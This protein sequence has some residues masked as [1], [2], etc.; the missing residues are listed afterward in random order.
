MNR[1]LL[2]TMAVLAAPAQAHFFLEAPQSAWAQNAVGDPQKRPPCGNEAGTAPTNAVTTVEAGSTLTI[3]FRET[4]FHPGHY[5]VALGLTGPGDLPEPAPVT[6]GATPCGSTTVQSP[7]VFP[8]LADGMLHHSTALTGTQSFAVTIPANVSC[9]RCTLQ[10]IQFM[11]DHALNVPGGC[12][13]SHCA[14]LTIVPRDAGTAPVRDAGLDTDGGLVDAGRPLG[15]DDAGAPPSDAGVHD[16]SG[17]DHDRDPAPAMGCGCVAGAG[18]L[19]LWLLA[20]LL[21]RRQY[22]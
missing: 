5:R 11:S 20:L 2:L 19:P 15:A 17:H 12:Y 21:R 6:P 7:P 8:V 13:Y 9:T 16:H 1:G 3:R 22:R 14:T 10:V 4:I 18:A